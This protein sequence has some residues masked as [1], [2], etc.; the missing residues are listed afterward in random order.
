M[1]GLD[2]DPEGEA[3]SRDWLAGAGRGQGARTARPTNKDAAKAH[4]GRSAMPM[5]FRA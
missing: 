1:G 2:R 5:M 4:C 3:G